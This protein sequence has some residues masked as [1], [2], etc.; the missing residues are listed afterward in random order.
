M[1][2]ETPKIEYPQ[3]NSKFMQA[4]Q[5]V[6]KEG[7]AKSVDTFFI[8]C[9]QEGVTDKDI[10]DLMVDYYSV[11]EEDFNSDWA[12]I[13]AGDCG[14]LWAYVID[15]ESGLSDAQVIYSLDDPAVKEFYR[16]NYEKFYWREFTDEESSR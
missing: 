6:F 10:L 9:D 13:Y 5:F 15:Q 14:E 3:S 7:G 2:P 1:F 16:Y 8:V 4:V 12:E 11:D